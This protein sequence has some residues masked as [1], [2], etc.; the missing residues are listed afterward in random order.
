MG[1]SADVNILVFRAVGCDE[2]A[3]QILSDSS[4]SVESYEFLKSNLEI[5]LWSKSGTWG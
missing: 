5:V 3:L 4:Y 2:Q 1:I